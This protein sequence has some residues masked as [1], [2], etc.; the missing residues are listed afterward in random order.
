MAKDYQPIRHSD[1]DAEADAAGESTHFITGREKPEPSLST[2]PFTSFRWKLVAAL[3]A[4]FAVSN[5]LSLAV[6]A[7]AGR[8]RA[9]SQHSLD[10]QCAAHTTQYS[11]LLDEVDVQYAPVKFNGSFLEETV[12]RHPGA[13]EVDAAWEALGVD[14]RA[15]VIPA[16]AGPRSGLTP[17][18]VQRADRYG[19]GF[20]VNVE[21]MHHLHCLVGGFFFSFFFFFK[22]LFFSTSFNSLF[23]PFSCYSFSTIC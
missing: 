20:L 11:P 15:G 19:G 13:P 22:Q 10:S 8:H 5:V 12:Y 9:L 17:G 7:Y 3:L 14:Y 21:G 1:D 18:H 4:A 2:S 6:G 16:E 23:P